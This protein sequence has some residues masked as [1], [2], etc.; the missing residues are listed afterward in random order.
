MRVDEFYYELPEEL[1]AQEP[2]EPRDAA[3]LLVLERAG[4]RLA[5][6]HFYQLPE[7]LQPGDCLVVNDSRVLPARLLGRRQPGGGAVEFLLLRRLDERRWEVLAKPGRR[8]QPGAAVSF[9][10]A[11]AAG[12]GSGE[13]SAVILAKT[14]AG[15]RLVE[16]SCREGTV[17]EQ[18][19]RLGRTPLPP[20]IKKDLADPERYQTIY[21]R[22]PGSAAAPTAGLHFTPELVAKLTQMGVAFAYVTLHVGLG[23]FRP[24][25]EAVVEKHVMHSE[26]YT[27]SP[28]A[29]GIINRAKAGGGRIVAVGTTSVRVLETQADPERPGLVRPGGGE[30]AIFIY[31]GFRFQVTD[32]LITNFHLPCSTLLMLVSA[33]AGRDLVMRAYAE[34]VEKRYRF[35]SFG[36]AMIII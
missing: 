17:D 34:A 13:L 36:D 22:H 10:A 20:Y 23:T 12:A 14:A 19:T 6:R 4:E 25:K 1:I 32:C 33:F 15:G 35:Y 9:G 16:F 26:A 11:P 28:E 7:M 3:R 30:T 29:A 18:L 8:L 2:V 24:V 5:H 31:P 21:N 27:L